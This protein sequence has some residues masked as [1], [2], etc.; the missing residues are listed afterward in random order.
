MST[1]STI[2]AQ[3]PQSQYGYS[4]QNPYPQNAYGYPAG[5]T[6]P[7]PR[8]TNS[9]YSHHNFTAGNTTLPTTR[10][11]RSPLPSKQ[12]SHSGP[13]AV[14]QSTPALSAGNRSNSQR[15]PDWNEFYKNGVPKEVIL[16]DDDTPPPTRRQV[17]RQGRRDGEAPLPQPTAGKK[18]KIDQSYGQEYHDS[19]AFSTHP[20]HFGDTA[21]VSSHSGTRTTSHQTTAPTSL[22]SY[23]SNAASNS[24]EDMNVGQK[25]KRAQPQKE[26]RAQAKKK[27]QEATSDAFNDY[28]PPPVPVRKAPEVHVPVIRDVSG[29]SAVRGH[30]TYFRKT[31]L[32]KN[33]KVD[34]DDGHY[35][36]TPGT[37]LTDRCILSPSHDTLRLLM[38][39]Q[40]KF[41]DYLGKAHLAKSSKHMTR[42]RRPNVPSRS[43]DLSRSIE[44][45]HESN[46]ECYR[47]SPSTT[48][49]TRTSVYTCV[50]L[51]TSEIIYA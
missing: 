12:N 14:S 11:Q 35:I 37:P 9:S 15:R 36:I 13:M 45:L 51:S 41:S 1:P 3:H 48:V 20:A 10:P 23:G 29:R 2:Q 6:L 44:M 33:A 18:R 39:T 42:K 19:P 21:S 31:S 28:I 50:T 5:N 34:D 46:C 7:A 27:Q 30:S 38:K 4:H 24:Y 22:E 47:L 8:M 40:T 43:S 32:P 17:S 25:R 26:T 16:I 49:P